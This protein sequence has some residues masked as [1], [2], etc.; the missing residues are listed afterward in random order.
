M[1]NPPVG[2]LLTFSCY[3]TR[4]HGDPRGS[5]DRYSNIFGTP[6]ILKNV[7]R[8]QA[9]LNRLEEPPLEEPPY[10]LDPL[11]RRIVLRSFWE[12]CLGLNWEFHAAHVRTDH[13]HM[14]AFSSLPPEGMIGL[15]KSNATKAL[16]SRAL[17]LDR[18]HRWTEDGS[19]RYLWNQNDILALSSTLW[20]ARESRRR[21]G[22]GGSLPRVLVDVCS[23]GGRSGTGR[24]RN[25]GSFLLAVCS[26]ANVGGG[27]RT[28]PSFPVR[29]RQ[30]TP[31]H[32]LRRRLG[33]PLGLPRAY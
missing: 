14:V 21:S 29:C 4:L 1:N 16:K 17:D 7:A 20:S 18:K 5:V 23:G 9:C 6:R 26:H 12:T 30:S 33:A 10:E 22:S 32:P 3:G 19:R 8:N 31:R 13:S 24:L 25:S 2:Y 11:R 28:W 15:L 27:L